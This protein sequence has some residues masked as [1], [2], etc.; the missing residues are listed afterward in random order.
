[1]SAAVHVERGRQVAPLLTIEE[2]EAGYAH[3]S[4]PLER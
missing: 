3:K 4:P 2:E 1:L